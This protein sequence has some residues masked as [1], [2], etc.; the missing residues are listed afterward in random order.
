MTKLDE[1]DQQSGGVSLLKVASVVFGN[2]TIVTGL[3]IYFGW[4]RVETQ[5]RRL[6]L[7]QTIFEFSIQ[8]YVLRSVRPVLVLLGAVAFAGV[9][10]LLLDRFVVLRLERLDSDHPRV[11]LWSRFL[12]SAWLVLPAPL[13]LMLNLSVVP[14]GIQRAAYVLWPLS[15]GAG[16]MLM[17]HALRTAG[18][19]RSSGH[20]HRI[21][22]SGLTALIGC[23]SLF[24]AGSNYADLE[25]RDVAKR[26][27]RNVDALPG[28]VVLSVDRLGIDATGVRETIVRDSDARFRYRTEG[29]R[30]LMR[31]GDEL[32]LLNRCWGPSE[33]GVLIRLPLDASVR[34]DFVFDR[35]SHSG[36]C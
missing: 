24:W 6:G 17:L 23:V 14:D 18:P 34:A 12:A 11:T 16:L 36:Q 8:D 10:W 29:L 7:D 13:V 3:L 25:G 27:G 4:R 31:S 21:A 32:L 9:A 30:L 20:Y 26:I 33:G 19:S 5:T 1:D 35:T 22:C 15:L 28:V 2:A